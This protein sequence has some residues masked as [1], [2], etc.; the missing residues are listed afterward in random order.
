VR[1][2]PSG[3][4]DVLVSEDAYDASGDFVVDDSFVVFSDDI[5]AEFLPTSVKRA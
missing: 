1:L 4:L 5:N 2:G 3:N